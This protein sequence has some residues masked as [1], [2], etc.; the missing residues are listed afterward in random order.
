MFNYQDYLS[1]EGS[2][3]FRYASMTLPADLYNYCG[4]IFETKQL[5]GVPPVYIPDSRNWLFIPPVYKVRGLVFDIT[6][7]YWLSGRGGWPQ[8]IYGRQQVSPGGS[9]GNAGGGNG[10]GQ[11]IQVTQP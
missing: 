10:L 1:L 2:Y 4:Y 3:R 7:T 11:G 9:G 6:E 5:P 8:P